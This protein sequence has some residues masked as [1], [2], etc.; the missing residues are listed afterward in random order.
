M[1]LPRSNRQLCIGD[2]YPD[3]VIANLQ[4][5]FTPRV[6]N[7]LLAEALE[8]S[9]RVGGR[10]KGHVRLAGL[11]TDVDVEIPYIHGAVANIQVTVNPLTYLHRRRSDYRPERSRD[12]SDNWLH[13]R[14]VSADNR[15]VWTLAGELLQ[16]AHNTIWEQMQR[17]LQWTHE[18]FTISPTRITVREVEIA[19]DL[20]ADDPGRTVEIFQP[21][22]W[23][24]F[25]HVK[26]SLYGQSASSY[27]SISASGSMI[28]GFAAR[29]LRI[30]MYE[31]TNS[32]V[33]LEASFK[34]PTTG[35]IGR[36]RSFEGPPEEE[37]PR[38]FNRVAQLALRQFRLLLG[39]ECAPSTKH[40][41]SLDLIFFIRTCVKEESEALDLLR[42]LVRVQ[43]VCTAA[44]GYSVCKSL[45]TRGIVRRS[46]HGVYKLTDQFR[47]AAQVLRSSDLRT[48]GPLVGHVYDVIRQCLRRFPLKLAGCECSQIRPAGRGYAAS[49][50]SLPS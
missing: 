27:R 36:T 10:M 24:H 13:S 47:R 21:A 28:E 38:V 42:A 6:S 20:A 30:K 31:K 9:G 33:R 43:R 16:S 45:L 26:R 5:T 49:L 29:N 22:F 50:V 11:D 7:V 3:K 8:I 41:S 32:R 40:R 14:V 48:L 34:G 25:A 4:F 37:F 44:F 15:A 19:V 12:G 17:G 46:G 1:A 39:D 23:R 35:F 18:E 2:L